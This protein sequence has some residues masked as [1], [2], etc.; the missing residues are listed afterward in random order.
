MASVLKKSI[1]YKGMYLIRR[2]EF[3][4]SRPKSDNGYKEYFIYANNK[5][6]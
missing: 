5:E 2:T 3:W 1:L 4:R 6:R